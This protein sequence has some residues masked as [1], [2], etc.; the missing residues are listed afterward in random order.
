MLHL[1]VTNLKFLRSL[2]PP[3]S[4]VRGN[5]EKKEDIL[6]VLMKCLISAQIFLD[7]VAWSL[8]RVPLFDKY[9]YEAKFIK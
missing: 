1:W 5:S 2:I 7:S 9:F 3:S 4:T 8:F 6:F